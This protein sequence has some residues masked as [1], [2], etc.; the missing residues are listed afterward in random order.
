MT[1]H[2]V[3]LRTV[4]RQE[5]EF[6]CDEQQ[7]VLDAAA[8][9]GYTLP[10]L[11]SKG[12]C[13]AASPGSPTG[14]TRW[15][16]TRTPR[17]PAAAAGWSRGACCSAG[18]WRAARS[19]WMPYDRA[20]IV[21][22]ELPVREASLIAVTPIAEATVRVE[23]QLDEHP[24][25]G[26]G[27]EFD[28]GQFLEVEVPGTDLR[29]AYSL[30]NPPNW[31]GRAELLIHLRPGGAFS[32]WLAEQAEPGA[33]LTV[34]G[35]QGAFGLRDH[36]VR[37]RWFVAGGMG[38]APTLSMMRRMAE[39]AE[40]QPVRLFLGVGTDS[41]VPELPELAEAGAQ[42]TDFEVTTSVWQPGPGWTARSAPRSTRSP[43]RSP[44]R[45]RRPTSTSADRPPWS[46]PRPRLPATPASRTRT[47]SLSG[48]C[49]RGVTRHQV[50]DV[51]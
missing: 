33:R 23:L 50:F 8:Q 28:P 35:P 31:D 20:R 48:T 7:W 21:D 10:S 47:S 15:G 9:A 26:S 39:W 17:S 13:G 19:R 6:D 43:T 27:L 32:T 11:C 44:G 12:T 1:Q 38:L 49:R 30:A 46:T 42:L 40:P 25:L 2:P 16:R 37:P 3:R 18:L 22:G 41:E 14:S 34:R 4:D 29:R 24:T 51:C 36:G 45:H 5:I